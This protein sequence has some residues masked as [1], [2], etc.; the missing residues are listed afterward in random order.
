MDIPDENQYSI[1]KII[2]WDNFR[3]RSHITSM[4]I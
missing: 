3:E 1:S 2:L 4:H